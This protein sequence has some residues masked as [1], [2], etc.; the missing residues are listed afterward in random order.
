MSESVGLE[1]EKRGRKGEKGKK[2]ES[3]ECIALLKLEECLARIA[4]AVAVAATTIIMS[5][6]GAPFPLCSAPLAR[7]LS[8]SLSFPLSL[9]L[10]RLDRLLSSIYVEPIF[11]AL[12]ESAPADFRRSPKFHLRI[13][14]TTKW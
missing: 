2:A 10:P 4:I 5:A 12:E 8:T 11:S 14:Y 1:G 13:F 9:S 7:S 3:G 6:M